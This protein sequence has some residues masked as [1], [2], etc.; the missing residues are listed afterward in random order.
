MPD[1]MALAV[2]EG[3]DFEEASLSLGPD[4]MLVLYTDGVTEA[5]NNKEELFGED[6]LKKALDGFV[7]K[8]IA[9]LPTGLR[10]CVDDFAGEVPQ[11]DDI[12]IVGLR[13]LG[14]GQQGS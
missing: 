10:K 7:D 14:Q 2:M 1:G 6:R 12:T 3:M 8:N 5:F 4:D 13:Y 11:A 9:D